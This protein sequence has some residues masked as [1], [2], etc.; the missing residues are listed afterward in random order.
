[1]AQYMGV[2]FSTSAA[3]FTSHTSSDASGV[4]DDGGV[5][6][7]KQLGNGSCSRGGV[8]CNAPS[9]SDLIAMRTESLVQPWH[10][11]QYRW[12]LSLWPE[13]MK[14]RSKVYTPF[15]VFSQV[16]HGSGGHVHLFQLY[17][18]EHCFRLPAPP[19][20]FCLNFLECCQEV[21][22]S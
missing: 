10:N 19:C 16:Q 21:H 5:C 11:T 7:S 15:D 8:G 18:G 20:D 1:M 12:A 6:S 14:E 3:S 17:V 22:V 9:P 13:E 4:R 2:L